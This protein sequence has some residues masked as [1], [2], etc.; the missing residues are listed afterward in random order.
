MSRPFAMNSSALVACWCACDPKSVLRDK[1]IPTV[2]WAL[3]NL[4]ESS[5]WTWIG[6][7]GPQEVEGAGAVFGE[8]KANF[9]SERRDSRPQT[10]SGNTR[11]AKQVQLRL[12]DDIDIQHIYT[13]HKITTTD[14][15]QCV[16]SLVMNR[17]AP[18]LYIR[19]TIASS[20]ANNKVSQSA[21]GG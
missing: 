3:P 9:T 1:L 10:H 13:C 8:L 6:Q 20:R 17:L 15:A 12:L 14:L 7:G 4:K 11:P 2:I 16:H 5:N 19:S 21:P 18:V